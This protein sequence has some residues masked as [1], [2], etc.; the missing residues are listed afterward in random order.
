MRARAGIL[1]LVLLACARPADPRNPRAP[2]R[3]VAAQP[4]A[5]FIAQMHRSI[6]DEWAWGF[7]E[8]LDAKGR[9]HPLNDFALWSRVE[10]V[11]DRDGN[12]ENVT[13]VR[14]SGS[15]AFD[16]AAREAVHA[17]G[18]FV[19]PPADIRSGNGKIYLH[20]A[21]HRDERACGTFGASPFVLLNP[22]D[23]DRPD[24]EN[25]ARGGRI[26][27]DALGRRPSKPTAPADAA[28]PAAPSGEADG[29]HPDARK[30]ANEWLHYFAV[31]DIERMLAR[32]SLPFSANESVAARTRDELREVLATMYA[33]ARAAGRPK[34]AKLFAAEGL[35]ELFGGVPS[36]VQQGQGRLFALTKVG[37]DYVILGKPHRERVFPPHGT[38]EMGGHAGFCNGAQASWGP[39]VLSFLAEFG[40]KR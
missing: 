7:L 28:G 32:T 29:D 2:S 9:Q 17:A 22:D 18:P 4:L 16:A 26:E 3:P 39:E 34:A 23:G 31:G 36:S 21:L 5:R 30:L 14:H 38:S 27:R 33:E 8:L 20:W 15:L 19:D 25:I 12:I 10:I 24:P 6:H 35:R 40:V 11:L 37:N 1:F 13:T